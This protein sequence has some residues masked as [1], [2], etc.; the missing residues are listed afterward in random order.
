M[1]RMFCVWLLLESRTVLR[2]SK[3]MGSTSLS[4]GVASGGI[5]P[6]M[7]RG[8]W[9]GMRIVYSGSQLILTLIEYFVDLALGAISSVGRF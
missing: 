5:I 4:P 3:L 6:R 8:L 1:P 2:V 9:C 7:S